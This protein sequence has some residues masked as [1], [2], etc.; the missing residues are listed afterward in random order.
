MEENKEQDQS[1]LEKY[2]VANQPQTTNDIDRLEEEYNQRRFTG[3]GRHEY[4]PVT[5]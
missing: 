4:F 3:M 1:D 2:I 5:R